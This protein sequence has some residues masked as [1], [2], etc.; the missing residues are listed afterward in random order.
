[1]EKKV[2]TIRVN[3]LI[4]A[5]EEKEESLVLKAASVLG[6]TAKE[7]LSFGVL[8]RALDARR[9]RPPHFVYSVKVGLSDSAVVPQTLPEGLQILPFADVPVMAYPGKEKPKA[10]YRPEQ[11]VVVIGGGPSGL[12]AAWVL[13][14]CGVPVLLMER[15]KRIEER[16]R[17]VRRFWEAGELNPQSNVLF[18]EG[19]A[20]TF[21]DGKLTSRTKNPYAGWVKKTLVEMG[22]PSSILTDAKPHVGTDRLRNV[23]LQL[24]NQLT[25]LGGVIQFE[26]QV[27][28]FLIRH[29]KIEAVVVNGGQEIRAGQ[30][31]LAIGQS[32]DDTYAILARRGVQMEAKA[33]AMGLR[34]EHP[35]CQINQLQYGKWSNAPELPPAEYFVT[36]AVQKFNR[37]V[38]TFCMCPGGRVIGCSAFPGGIITNGMSN[39]DRSEAFANS[40]LVVNV[41]EEDFVKEGDPLSG[42]RFRTIWEQKAFVAGGGDYFAPAQKLS[43]FVERKYSGAI[44]R[45]SFLPGVRAVPLEDVLPEFV[46][47]SLRAGLLRFEQKMPGF[48]SPDAHLIGVETRTSSP[49]RISRNANGQSENI[50]GL[51]PCG[52]GAG[53]AGGIIS[54]ALDGMKAAWSVMSVLNGSPE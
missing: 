32:A 11:P 35:Q 18:G 41:R 24:R 14:L 49:V 37:S 5:L 54:S 48:I 51:Y 53:Y 42:L 33:F 16:V 9:N 3:G 36:A 26:S 39:H 52:E 46:A 15:G 43:E 17:D 7:I 45:T 6:I 20:G 34:V 38:Y 47:C 25:Q 30:V 2:Q 22:A 31:I 27:T 4:L 21:S 44:G 23:I 13:A 29:G 12:F 10:P 8:K 28:D 19:G 40:A 50:Q 1:M